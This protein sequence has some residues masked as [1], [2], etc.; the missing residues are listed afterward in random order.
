A[1]L[2]LAARVAAVTCGRAGAAPPTRDE[3]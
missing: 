1:A 2:G 3:L